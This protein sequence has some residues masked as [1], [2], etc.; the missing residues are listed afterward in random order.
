MEYNLR[1]LLVDFWCL[2][3]IHVFPL[4]D[5]SLMNLY[6]QE[7]VESTIFVPL[8]PIWSV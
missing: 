5:L 3:I 2:Q 4:T 1:V 7:N 8:I 6:S